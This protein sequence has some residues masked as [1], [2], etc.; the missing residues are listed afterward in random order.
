[1]MKLGV[2]FTLSVDKYRCGQ[3]VWNAKYVRLP[4]DPTDVGMNNPTSPTLKEL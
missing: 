1:M 2:S 3:L 4:L